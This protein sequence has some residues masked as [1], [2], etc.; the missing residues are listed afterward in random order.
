MSGII[1]KSKDGIEIPLSHNMV[2]KLEFDKYLANEVMSNIIFELATSLCLGTTFLTERDLDI[3]L[4]KQLSTD[5]AIEQ[6]N[7]LLQKY[8]T[9]IVPFIDSVSPVDLIKLRQKEGESF[10]LFQNALTKALEEYREKNTEITVRHAKAIYGDI[11]QPQLSRLDAKV[12]SAKRKLIKQ[13]FAEVE[14][15]A[16]AISI[17]LYAG[18]LPSGMAAAAT[19]LGLTKVFAELTQKVLANREYEEEIRQ[20]QMYFLWKVKE[21]SKR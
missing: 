14:G 16:A 19:A 7:Q 1:K 17:G 11:I 2:R 21:L 8:L 20:D 18:L 6:R 15:W 5:P 12:N 10:I 4:L 9:C 13:T 3:Q